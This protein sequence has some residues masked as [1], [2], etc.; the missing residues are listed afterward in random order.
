MVVS[1]RNKSIKKLQKNR[2]NINKR[3]G[4][5]KYNNYK[6]RTLKGGAQNDNFP[7]SILIDAN[8]TEPLLQSL[9]ETFEIKVIS[10]EKSLQI[11][12]I[13][14]EWVKKMLAFSEQKFGWLSNFGGTIAQKMANNVIFIFNFDEN[15]N[16][17][18]LI[19]SPIGMMQINSKGELKLRGFKSW[20][21]K[22][23]IPNEI[24]KKIEMQIKANY[25]VFIQSIKEYILFVKNNPKAF[26]YILYQ[27][28]N[29]KKELYELFNILNTFPPDINQLDNTTISNLLKKF[30]DILK[31]SSKISLQSFKQHFSFI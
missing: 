10:K 24:Y 5:K 22:K 9:L 17:T 1:K 29:N 21:I 30:A 19:V 16:I 25:P 18:T 28:M 31:S 20:V 26:K 27:F 3:K 23:F 7:I 11:F 13:N 4:T 12:F 6:K 15:N 8:G 2:L 14:K